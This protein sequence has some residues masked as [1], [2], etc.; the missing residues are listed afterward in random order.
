MVIHRAG[1]CAHPVGGVR[2]AVVVKS[3]DCLAARVLFVL[4]AFDNVAALLGHAARNDNFSFAAHAAVLLDVDIDHLNTAVDKRA[5][6][7]AYMTFYD[8]I[9][10]SHFYAVPNHVPNVH[11]SVGQKQYS[12]RRKK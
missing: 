10:P 3:A 9:Y 7:L 4:P 1:R 2:S 11:P 12:N 5:K 6:E 8:P